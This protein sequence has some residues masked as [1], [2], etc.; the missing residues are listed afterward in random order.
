MK[1]PGRPMVASTVGRVR[2]SGSC[3]RP[4]PPR[5][6][7]RPMAAPTDRAGNDLAPTDTVHVGGSHR[8]GGACPARSYNR[9]SPLPGPPRASAPTDTVHVGGSR[10]RGG[11][12]P[13]RS[14]NRRYPGRAKARP[15]GH[16]YTLPSYFIFHFPFRNSPGQALA[17]PYGHHYYSFFNLQ[18]SVFIRY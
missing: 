4:Q 6:L 14:Y 10:R 8:R 7:A 3:A 2:R 15:Y 16:Q 5:C 13:A 1:Y 12:C 11:A 18:F 9:R 17:R